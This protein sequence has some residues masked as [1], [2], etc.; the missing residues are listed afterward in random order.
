VGDGREHGDEDVGAW[1]AALERTYPSADAL[2]WDRP[3][4]QVG[5]P[6]WPVARV[7]VSL[8][9]TRT[10]LDEAAA[11]EHTLLVAH[12]PLL[13]TP[14][15]SL[16]PTTAPGA[17]ALHAAGL[18]VAV[19][20]AHTNHDAADDGSGT[21]DPVVRV[22]AL[23]AVGPLCPPARPGSRPLG[24]VGDLPEPLTLAEV[25]RKV[26]ELLPAPHLRLVGDPERLVRRVAILGGSGGSAVGDALA[27]RADVLVTGDVRHHLALDA[28]ELGLAL[29]D[30][31]HHATEV[32]ALP[33]MRAR[34]EATARASGLEAPVVVA[35]TST[36]P[37]SLP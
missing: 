28:L 11:T 34:L 3:G 31:G 6:A 1:L 35:T 21:S 33:A 27:A 12:H 17:L 32:A 13:L 26:R 22:L 24:R 18:A 29:I 5:D 37:W 15:V 19:A 7:L 23:R 4:L 30:A 20:A 25:G 8:D 14:L 10:V 2:D 9:V 16:T 36:V